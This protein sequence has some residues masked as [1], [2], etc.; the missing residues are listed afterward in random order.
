MAKDQAAKENVDWFE[1]DL[2][3]LFEHGVHTFT[4]ILTERKSDREDLRAKEWLS[5]LLHR[6]FVPYAVKKTFRQDAHAAI[7]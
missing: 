3:K 4:L 7:R 2:K 5:G 1:R 6:N